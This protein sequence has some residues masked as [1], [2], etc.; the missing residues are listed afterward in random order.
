LGSEYSK[1]FDLLLVAK[2]ITLNALKRK[3]TRGCHHREDYPTER[4]SYRKVHLSL[5]LNDLWSY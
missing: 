1:I 2:S 3:E 5:D 4:E